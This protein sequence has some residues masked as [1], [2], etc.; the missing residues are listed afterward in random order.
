MGMANLANLI[1]ESK[2]GITCTMILMISGLVKNELKQK[3]LERSRKSP[4][5]IDTV[6]WP[7]DFTRHVN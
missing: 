1:V 7:M 6:P 2:E 3:F 4:N 5:P